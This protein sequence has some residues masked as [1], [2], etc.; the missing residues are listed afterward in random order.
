MLC[1]GERKKG[2]LEERESEARLLVCAALFLSLHPCSRWL[3]CFGL[4]SPLAFLDLVAQIQGGEGGRAE[5]GKEERGREQ[6]QSC[7]GR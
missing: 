7:G 1:A 6:T 2:V 5:E 4:L 3:L